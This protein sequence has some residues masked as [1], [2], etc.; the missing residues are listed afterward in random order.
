MLAHPLWTFGLACGQGRSFD[1]QPAEVST[2]E[3][4]EGRVSVA[5][6]IDWAETRLANNHPRIGGLVH[7]VAARRGPFAD[8]VPLCMSE[9]LLSPA[10]RQP[11]E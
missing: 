11:C 8:R 7:L 5:S 6:G 4:G 3:I 10:M 1:T 9:C 2:G